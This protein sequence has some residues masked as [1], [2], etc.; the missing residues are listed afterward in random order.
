[1]LERLTAELRNLTGQHSAH[2]STAATTNSDAVR[3]PSNQETNVASLSEILSGLED[4][5][6]GNSAIKAI[7]SSVI[8]PEGTDLVASVVSGIASLEAK[9]EADKAAAVEQAK[10]EATAAAAAPEQS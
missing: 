10:A 2:S 6:N 5:L 1:M 7:V 3:N 9:H 8:S 4:A